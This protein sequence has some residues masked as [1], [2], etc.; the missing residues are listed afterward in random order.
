MIIDHCRDFGELYDF[1]TKYPMND[2]IFSFNFI[3]NNP[4]L[5]CAY[6]EKTGR[7]KAYANI[8]QDDGEIFLSGAS[9]R[10]NMPDNIAFIIKICKAFN[11]DMYADTDIKAVKLILLKSGFKKISNNKYVRYKNNG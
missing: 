11:C 7:L 2:G 8:Y 1:Y 4:Y 10:K 3:K 6:D 9:I 5:I